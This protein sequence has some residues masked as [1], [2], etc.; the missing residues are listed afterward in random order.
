MVVLVTDTAMTVT[1]GTLDGF[2]TTVPTNEAKLFLN[3]AASFFNARENKTVKCV[4]LDVAKFRQ[5]NQTNTVLRSLLPQQDV[6]TIFIADNRS[7]TSTTE[8]GVRLINGEWLPPKGLTVATPD[9]MYIKGNYN[10]TT[11]GTPVNLGTSDTS[12]ALP[13]SVAADAVSILSVNWNDASSASALSSRIAGSTTVNCAILAG[14]VP[15]TTSSY[16]GGLE[17][18]PRF[19]EDWSGQTLTYNGSWVAMY[20]SRI[21]TAPWSGNGASVSIYSPP[22]RNWSFDQNFND[23]NKIPPA[24]PQVRLL[25]RGGWAD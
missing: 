8:P 5:W 17:N 9:P 10:V 16:S 6:Q 24:S 11:N 19:L 20:D 7:Q 25:L 1:S 15:T 18:F 21:A 14:N 12:A 13:A 4:D 3:T 2:A 23:L 22:I